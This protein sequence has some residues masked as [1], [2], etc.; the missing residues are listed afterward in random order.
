MLVP[1]EPELASGVVD[2]RE[3]EGVEVLLAHPAGGAMR[4][5]MRQ[6]RRA[7]VRSG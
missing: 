7:R 5:R 4:R 2:G 6:R 3:A 1:G